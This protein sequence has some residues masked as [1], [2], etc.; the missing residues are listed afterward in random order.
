MNNEIPP[1][2][3][4]FWIN[5][6]FYNPLPLDIKSVKAGNSTAPRSPSPHLTD[7]QISIALD[8][9][10]MQLIENI[11]LE[12]SRASTEV[13]STT[14]S[15][16]HSEFRTSGGV[17]LH[18]SHFPSRA[19]SLNERSSLADVQWGVPPRSSSAHHSRSSF[20]SALGT[21]YSESAQVVPTFKP[22]ASAPVQYPPRIVSA[23]TEST[24]SRT[25]SSASDVEPLP[26]VLHALDKE[27]D[28]CIIV[29]RRI[30]RLGFKSNRIIKSRFEHMGWD[31]RNVVLL[32]SRSRPAEGSPFGSVPHA[33]PSSMGFVVFGN[34]KQ[35]AEC[36]SL[37]SIDVDGIEVL[38]Q[39]FARQYKPTNARET[40]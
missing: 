37:G 1:G 33:R 9:G 34:A 8:S 3:E 30:T 19:A 5:S 40:S 16:I 4:S 7:G 2:Y 29:V 32:P 6:E 17:D 15:G 18:Q 36:L 13:P 26:Q 39:P 10:L 22:I 24:T 14:G 12:I 11:S 38:V 31:V 25:L 27:P 23:R 21:T 28:E 20:S 35:A